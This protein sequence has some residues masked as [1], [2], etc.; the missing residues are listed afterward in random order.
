MANY[1]PLIADRMIGTPLLLEPG[2]AQTLFQVLQA[3]ITRGGSDDIGDQPQDDP[4]TE[5][6]AFTGRRRRSDGSYSLARRAGTV[7]IVEIH[8]SL[9]NRGAWIGADSGLTSYE[10]IG[11]QIAAAMQDDEVTAIILDI[12][13]PGGEA[14]GMFGLAEKVRAANAV[15]PVIAV[16]DDLAA[17]AA[18]G[19]ASGAHEI[20]CSPTSM[21]GSIGVVLVHMD[22]SGE[23]EK[24][25]V[26]ATI[27][28]A[29]ANK[30]DGHP[31]GPLSAGVKDNLQSRVN[32]LYDRFLETVE[33]GRGARM[34]ASAA[35]Q[36]EAN[37]FIG[38]QAID[39]NL[40]DRIGTFETVLA[41][42]QQGAVSGFKTQDT[43][44]MATDKAQPTAEVNAVT[45]A[46]HDAAVTQAKADGVKEGATQ[47][48]ARIS[49]IMSSDAAKG[50]PKAAMAMALNSDMSAESAAAVLAETA[51]EGGTEKAAPL[52]VEERAKGEAEMGGG[53]TATPPAEAKA[54]WGAAIAEANQ[55]V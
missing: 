18:Y 4:E 33:N 55:R 27:I 41:E 20:V 44:T 54:G 25:G 10:G 32:T 7:A 38:Q 47:E 2:K 21:I 5:A 36:T 1:L 13:S 24:K 48:R 17:S 35:R 43:I 45:Q 40:A 39:R 42:L 30:V 19:I 50:R 46:A 34:N 53:D 14:T 9:V 22:H 31:F 8:G 6:S 52:T 16:V 26:K 3:R 12:D 23:L 37:V 29:G 11:A 51:L 15:K 49:S 28:H